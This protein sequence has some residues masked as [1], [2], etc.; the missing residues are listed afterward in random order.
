M[1]KRLRRKKHPVEENKWDWAWLYY[2][3]TTL[4]NM[5]DKTFWSS[6]LRKLVL[7]IDEHLKINGMVDEEEQE[8]PVD[9]IPFLMM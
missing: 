1:K 4:L 9:Q 3:G 5:D 6:T 2:A 7:L 8:T